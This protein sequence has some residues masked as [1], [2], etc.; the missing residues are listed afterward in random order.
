MPGRGRSGRH[1]RQDPGAEA[2]EK[3]GPGAGTEDGRGPPGRQ[4]SGLR[5]REGWLRAGKERPGSLSPAGRE[6]QQG[7]DASD[8]GPGRGMTARTMRT[9]SGSRWWCTR[10]PHGWGARTMSSSRRYEAGVSAWLHK[11]LEDPRSSVVWSTL[12]SPSVLSVTLPRSGQFGRLLSSWRI[13]S[14]SWRNSRSPSWPRPFL[15]RV[16]ENLGA[17]RMLDQRDFGYCSSAQVVAREI[18]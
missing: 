16:S 6:R 4:D 10:A 11:G 5:G 9:R 3:S 12:L 8:P 1:A 14:E 15:R 13:K 2:G 17:D 18:C 7:S